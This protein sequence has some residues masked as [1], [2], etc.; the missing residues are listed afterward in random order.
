LIYA[1]EIDDRNGNSSLSII[2][3]Y[4]CFLLASSIKHK[5]CTWRS[6][7]LKKTAR[8]DIDRHY[9]KEEAIYS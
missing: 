5:I 8:S 4:V 6:V 7:G 1:A 3:L 9:N 2:A